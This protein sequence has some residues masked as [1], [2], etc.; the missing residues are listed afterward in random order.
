MCN[1]EQNNV[2]IE[3]QDTDNLGELA[4][5]EKL[6]EENGWQHYFYQEDECA[7]DIP[8]YYLHV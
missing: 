5:S 1:S 4:M 2:K 7:S 8:I 3:E 6:V